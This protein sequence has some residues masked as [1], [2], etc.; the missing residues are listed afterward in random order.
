MLAFAGLACTDKNDPEPEA[1]WRLSQFN[2]ATAHRTNG[3]VIFETSSR[4]TYNPDGTLKYLT[5]DTLAATEDSLFSQRYSFRY[6]NGKL[7]QVMDYY[8][9]HSETLR[10]EIVRDGSG[11]IIIIRDRGNYPAGSGAFDTRTITYNDAGKINKITFRGNDGHEEE[12]IFTWTGSNVT[13]RDFVNPRLQPRYATAQFS[14]KTDIE[15]ATLG[16]DIVLALQYEDYLALSQHQPIAQATTFETIGRTDN[17]TQVYSEH[18]SGLTDK[19]VSAWDASITPYLTI[20][21]YLYE[22]H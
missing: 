15:Y 6:Q 19:K 4:L 22:K 7:S 2:V 8:R 21:R 12:I 9:N 13:R 16:Q 18:A 3:T 1:N 11:R 10:N 14:G 5:R 20:T 17:Y